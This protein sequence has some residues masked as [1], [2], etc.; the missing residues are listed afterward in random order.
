[1]KIK[2]FI[3]SM[4][5][6]TCPL[7]AMQKD[8]YAECTYDECQEQ[9]TWVSQV[10]REYQKNYR[11][12]VSRE[13]RKMKNMWRLIPVQEQKKI[14]ALLN[15]EKIVTSKSLHK[16]VV[17]SISESALTKKYA[18][19][20]T[21]VPYGENLLR[22]TI[23]E[24]NISLAKKELNATNIAKMLILLQVG[25]ID[26]QIGAGRKLTTALD[27]M[28]KTY[29]ENAALQQFDTNEIDPSAPI[30]EQ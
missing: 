30:L 29:V 8:Q 12:P 2:H 3:Y 27:W 25:K 11:I 23:N 17:L 22:V 13:V 28:T 6:M 15:Q 26:K 5:L 1:M 19:Q 10:Q 4:V 14:I 20:M 16:N 24:K 18:Q 9:Q 21:L 7:Y